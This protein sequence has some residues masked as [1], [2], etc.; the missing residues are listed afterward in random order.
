M[1]CRMERVLENMIDAI[2]RS[3]TEE[4]QTRLL[5]GDAGADVFPDRP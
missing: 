4:R 2:K 5:Y 1:I 3:T